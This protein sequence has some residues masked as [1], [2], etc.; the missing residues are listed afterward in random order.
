MG[1][2]FRYQLA[3]LKKLRE[4][5]LNMAK[6]ELAAVTA[7]VSNCDQKIVEAQGNIG[8][9]LDDQRQT[10]DTNYV[11]LFSQLSTSEHDK[12]DIEM[13]K[14]ETLKADLD[15]HSAYVS[16]LRSELKAVEHHEA[17][18]KEEHQKA[19]DKRSEK[20]LDEVSSIMWNRKVR[21]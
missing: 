8:Q 12:I 9:L 3:S 16:F 11:K 1:S 7:L 21:D 2:K 14:R 5:K 17:A 19:V 18:K 4:L 10:S 20:Q 15:R 13:K 6:A